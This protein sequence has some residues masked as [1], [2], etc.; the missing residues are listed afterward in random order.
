[1]LASCASVI[2]DTRQPGLP[3]PE[4]AVALGVREGP[5]VAG[6]SLSEP[7]AAAALASFRESCPR[8]MSRSDG[9]GLTRP[10][11][12]REPCTAAANWGSGSAVLFFLS[13]FETAQIGDGKAFATGYYEPEIAG[14]R[15]RQP[16]FDVP[17][18][19]L[20]PDLVRAKTGDA[21][22]LGNGRMPLGR[23]GRD[24]RFMQYYDRSAIEQ[25][26]LMGRGLE[27]AWAADPVELFFLQVQGSGRLRGPDGTVMR[28]GYAG[29]NGQ[30][31]TGI[32]K[33]MRERGLIGDGP[34]QYPGSM[35]GIM[36]YIREHPAEGR[37]LMDENRSYVFFRELTGDGPLGALNV[38]VRAHS[39]VAADP[40][41]VPL[42]APVWLDLD[43]SEA[44]GL[45]IAQDTGGAIKGANRFDTFWGAGKE[46]RTTAGGMSGH[47][48]ALL[49]LPKGT[50]AR[51]GA[52]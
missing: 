21:K 44:D 51:L 13:Y 10:G 30:P 52:R 43:R 33:V 22:P 49:L 12:W 19:G 48:K 7:D 38:P 20:P 28:I 5:S 11:D 32:G 23:Y 31:Y 17:V 42:G 8:L 34:G 41:F 50:L 47:G 40:R 9:S 24:G 27:I 35:Q 2:P 1:M 45:W 36:Q 29:Q 46:A 15:R 37:A 26:V 3:P 4:N 16:G 25:G 14:V 18:Y 6:L 39:S